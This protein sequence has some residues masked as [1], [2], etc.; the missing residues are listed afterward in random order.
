MSPSASASTSTSTDTT[1]R[2]A[3]IT[4]AAEG[5][6]HGIALRLAKDG[7]DL[8]LF[9][10]P[11][12]QQKLDELAENI[13]KE[14]GVRVVN[15]LG[16]VSEEED[17]KRLVDTVVQELGSLYAMIANAGIS[18]N[19]VLHETPTA[20]MDRV[21]GVNFKGTFFCYKYAAMQMIKQ[22][23][24]GRILGASSIAGKKGIAEQAVYSAT[25]FAIRGMTQCA[26]MDYGKYGITVNAYAPGVIETPLMGYLDEYH[27]SKTGQPKGSWTKSFNNVNVLGRNGQPEDV[28]KL[29]S[30]LVS[31]DAS[32]ITGQTYLVDGGIC[33][34]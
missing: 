3:I 33:F 14:F 8:G 4:G 21:L 15:V 16:D 18:I 22:G 23:K 1:K 9:D 13:R 25:K 17:V 19:R 10:L 24:G 2:V 12:S 5:I 28:A 7:F 32:F 20:E 26:A 34:D 27:T 31:D 11:R 29:V 6:G 30:F